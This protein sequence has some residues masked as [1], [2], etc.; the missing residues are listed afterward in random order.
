MRL[1][2]PLEHQ[3]AKQGSGKQWGTDGRF[4]NAGGSCGRREAETRHIPAEAPAFE[5]FSSMRRPISAS[6]FRLRQKGHSKMSYRT[7]LLFAVGAMAA[8]T[9]MTTPASAGTIYYCKDGTAVS[10]PSSCKNYG[11]CCQ[12]RLPKPGTAGRPSISD[13]GAAGNLSNY[14]SRQQAR[15]GL[16]E[17][18]PGR[19]FPQ[20]R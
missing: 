20:P 14:R 6:Q 19:P 10:Y 5:L 9:V 11:G 8:I 4:A 15:D 2:P 12:K 1:S 16:P 7:N 3:T 18:K 17:R 13:Q